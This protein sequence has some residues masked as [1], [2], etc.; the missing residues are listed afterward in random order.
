MET[1]TN[2]TISMVCTFGNSVR[3]VSLPVLRRVVV[4][5]IVGVRSREQ[6]LQ[7]QDTDS[8]NGYRYEAKR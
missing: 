8:R 6:S 7:I 4:Q 2:K 3:L 1:D 5:G